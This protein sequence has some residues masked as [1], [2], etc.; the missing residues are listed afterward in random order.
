MAFARSPKGDED[1]DE[2]EQHRMPLIE[3]LKELRN[4]LVAAV[5]AVSVGMGISWFYVNE[6]L[7]FL[8]EP[9]KVALV[10]L[11]K[12]PLVSVVI[13]NPF[14]GMSTWMNVAVLGGITLASPVVAYQLWAFIAPGLYH[15]ERRMVAPLAFSSAGLFLA[16]GG[17]CYY[18]MFPFAFPFFFSVLDVG[19]QL[20]VQAYLSAVLKMILGF[21]VCF[22]L[23]IATYF[24]ARMGLMDH[25]DMIGAFRY[26]IVGIFV[27]AAILTPPDILSQTLL[28]VPL[29]LLYFVS[30]GVA[31]AF[32]TKG[33]LDLAA[34]DEPEA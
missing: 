29:I 14:E 33:Q 21:G 22:Q 10:G 26:A 24:V 5:A 13:I 11:G 7:D 32:S 3:H 15:T 6:I 20:S 28:A 12:D 30:I 18:V 31:W 34:D 4:R 2:V 17:F 25:K 23:P 1:Q 16:G 9:A 27:V 8:L 19:V